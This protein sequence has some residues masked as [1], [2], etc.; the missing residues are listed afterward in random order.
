MVMVNYSETKEDFYEEQSE[1]GN[2]LQSWFHTSRNE[3]TNSFVNKYYKEKGGVVDLGCG[4]V[5]WNNNHLTVTGVDV[6][7][8]FL[9]LALRKGRINKKI[10]SS[11]ETTPFPDSSV[12]II[13]ITEV[14]EHV[15]DLEIQMKEIWRILKPGG[16]VI[17]SVPYDTN[18]S[19]WKP[20]FVAQCFYQGRI[21]GDEYYKK[22]CGHINHFSKI[23]IMKLFERN[24]FSVVEQYNH[25]YFTIFTIAQK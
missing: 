24:K 11:I 15:K 9:D 25:A 7:E 6:N 23:S 14:I 16:Y 5:L 4:N 8:G 13:V 1:S 12:E 18:F 20:L 2:F 10:I 17:S 3:K 19:L 22:E 21:K